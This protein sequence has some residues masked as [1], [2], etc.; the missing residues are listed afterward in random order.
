M[1]VPD[2]RAEMLHVVLCGMFLES[3]CPCALTEFLL[4]VVPLV[5]CSMYVHKLW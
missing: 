1:Y 3:H 2:C 5:L 4:S